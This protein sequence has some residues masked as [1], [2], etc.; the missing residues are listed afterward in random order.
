MN[1]EN[2]WLPFELAFG[3]TDDDFV[4]EKLLDNRDWGFDFYLLT[5]MLELMDTYTDRN[6]LLGKMGEA[7]VFYNINYQLRSKGLEWTYDTKPNTYYMIPQYRSNKNGNGGQ[8]GID[9]YIRMIDNDGLIHRCMVEV[10]NWMHMVDGI[11]D[12]IYNKKIFDKFKE[13]DRLCRCHRISAIT[14]NN[15]KEL[16]ERF[17]RD[18]ISILPIRAHITPEYIKRRYKTY[19]EM[20]DKLTKE[21]YKGI[22]FKIE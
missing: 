1:V 13:Y 3:I 15:I 7:F 8:G 4:N 2:S 18:D 19:I 21:P 20:T 5:N 14:K 9:I 11:P 10:S 22:D 17:D 16:K 6:N 12:E